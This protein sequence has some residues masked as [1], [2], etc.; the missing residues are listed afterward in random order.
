MS[1]K[2]PFFETN[3]E[4]REKII[5]HI[6]SMPDKEK[7]KYSYIWL[8]E[9]GKDTNPAEVVQF[10]TRGNENNYSEVR[11]QLND[12][13]VVSIYWVPVEANRKGFGVKTSEL[14]SMPDLVRRGYIQHT[15]GQAGEERGFTYRIEADDKYLYVSE[16]GDTLV[17]ADKDL[18]I[19]EEFGMTG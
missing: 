1:V 8:A 5:D 6:S 3:G 13:K 14:N 7:K 12:N 15:V 17:T 18:N 16:E 11:K 10:D 19:V 4:K 2:D 9:L